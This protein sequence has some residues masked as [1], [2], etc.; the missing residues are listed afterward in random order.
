MD[1]I[2]AKEL[3]EDWGVSL[4]TVQQLCVNG[5]ITG[6]QKIGT[7]WMI[8]KDAQK[9]AR[10]KKNTQSHQATDTCSITDFGYSLPMPLLNTPFKLGNAKA[11]AESF[12][13]PHQRNI[14]LA[15]YYYF[16]GNSKK[17]A[18]IT[19]QYLDSADMGQRLSAMWIYAYASLALDNISGAKPLWAK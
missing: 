19:E 15:E 17:A 4:R 5:K 1:Y 16:S 11:C 7:Q 9:P 13:D 6:A 8:P 2:T 3:A 18:A 12:K 10:Q 14:A